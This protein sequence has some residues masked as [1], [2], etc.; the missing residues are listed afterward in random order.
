MFQKILVYEN[1]LAD[2]HPAFERALQ[3]ARNNEVELKLSAQGRQ[4]GRECVGDQTP[5][6]DGRVTCRHI[7]ATASLVAA[8]GR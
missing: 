4:R 3:L 8:A 7:A 6:N 1:A 2:K 5:K